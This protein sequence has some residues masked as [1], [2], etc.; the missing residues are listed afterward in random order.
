MNFPRRFFV[1]HPYLSTFSSTGSANQEYIEGVVCQ[2]TDI[3]ENEMKNFDL[4]SSKVLIV[5]QKGKI[6][7]IGTKC[8][9]YGALLAT[10]ALGDGRIRCPWHGACFNI[11]T[12]DIE[13]FPGQDSIP[14]YEVKVEQGQV[15]VRAKKSDLEANKRMKVMAQ[16]DLKDD[17]TFLVIGGGPSGAICVDTIR[18]NGFTGRV[19]I[20]CKEPLLPYDRIKV[21]KTMDVQPESL[22]LRTQKFYDDNHI[23]TM[24]NVEATT[25]DAETKEVSLNNGYKI[26]YDK[27]YVATGSSPRKADIPGANLTNVVTLRNIA[28]SHYV[29]D[30]LSEE[31]HVV[32]L[33]VSFIGLEAACYCVKKAAKVTVIGR[34][35]VPLRP[36]F[37]EA[38]GG[39]IMKFFEE[40]KVEFVMNSGIKQ[41]NGSAAG[42]LESVE[43]NDGT[44]LKA[45]ICI[46]G[47]GSTLNTEFLKGSGL[48]INKDG[49]IDTNDYLQ[50]SLPDVYIGGDIA[51]SPVFSSGDK[52]ATIGH[53][54][55][56]QHHGR[57]AALNMVGK[58]EELH[59][60]PFFWAMLFGKS[61]RYCGHG[62]PADI[63]VEGSIEDMKFVAFY[64]DVSGNVIAMSSC[65]KDP[66]VSQFAE[67]LSQGR[68]L[69][70]KDIQED[71][72]AWIQQLNK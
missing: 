10:G 9:H 72:F 44:V 34:D 42:I 52:L 16:R 3:G 26:K 66:I 54:S 31:T 37:G 35:S 67:Y 61:F 57:V 36:V 23:E 65:G 55:L 24:I 13:D 43:L 50:S 22:L 60:V 14:C 70:R 51:N 48:N 47:V 69:T 63:H 38:V 68:T 39:R 8:T 11:A 46:M 27:V 33:G 64:L 25:L 62:K 2:E 29:N 4:G 17:R 18:Q 5:K 53:Y 21:S 59:V 71:A 56:A 6:S 49:S 41:C 30:R 1:N 40:N 32:V 12:G 7:A 58:P 19:V 15:T 45:D 20:V 28:D